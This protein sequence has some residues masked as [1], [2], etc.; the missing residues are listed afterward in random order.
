MSDNNCY[1][2]VDVNYLKPF[3]EDIT[4]KVKGPKSMVLI[5]KDDDLIGLVFPVR[6][7]SENKEI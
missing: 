3:G 1:A 6:I 4:Y 7:S 2:W 5:Y